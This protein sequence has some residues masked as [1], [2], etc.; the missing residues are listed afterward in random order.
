M[1]PGEKMPGCSVWSSAEALRIRPLSRGHPQDLRRFNHQSQA[2]PAKFR[3]FDVSSGILHRGACH[4][5]PDHR[6]LIAG[7]LPH[8][9][10]LNVEAVTASASAESTANGRITK[11]GCTE[12]GIAR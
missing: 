10:F 1:V 4:G 2:G 5:I 9:Y 11:F 7:S 6:R 3:L 8:R 12:T